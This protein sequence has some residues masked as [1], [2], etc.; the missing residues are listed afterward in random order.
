MASRKEQTIFWNQKWETNDT[1]F[2]QEQ[3]NELL[4]QFLPTLSLKPRDRVFV[5]LCGKSIDMLWLLKQGYEVTG[6]ELSPLAPEAFFKGHHLPYQR[7][8]S[9]MFT[10]FYNEK[11]N[12][13]AG[14]FFD[15]EA[16][17]LETIHATFDRAALIALPPELRRDYAEKMISLLQPNTS[18][19]LIALTYNQELMSG[20][21]FSVDE[22]EVNELYSNYFRIEKLF[23]R[24]VV[25]ISPHLQAKGLTTA[26]E[27]VYL[28]SKMK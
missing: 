10:L 4:K 21:P 18:M 6:V 9:D 13:F 14:D 1:P 24:A 8:N 25:S 26:N 5:P 27:Q 23:D 11:I 22:E 3:P 7:K 15:L 19:L 12:L 28:L 17:L 2:N 16:P 20:P